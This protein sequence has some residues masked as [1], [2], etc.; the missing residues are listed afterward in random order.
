MKLRAKVLIPIG[1]VF[2][3]SFSAFIFFL[4]LDQSN[5]KRANLNQEMDTMTELVGTT[6]VAYLWNMDIGGLEQS[7]TSFLK[8]P[9]IVAVEIQDTSGKAVATLEDKEKPGEL[10]VKTVEI[11]HEGAKIGV[12]NVTFTDAIL[13]DEVQGIILQLVILG[14]FVFA[15]LMTVLYFVTN[16]FTKPIG[17]LLGIV[18]DMAQGEGNLAVTIPVESRDEIGVLSGHFNNFLG[19]LRTIVVNLRDVGMK[20]RTLGSNLE[21]STRDISSSS[22][23]IAASMKSMGERTNYLYEQIRLSSDGIVGINMSIDKVVEMIDAQAAA[24]NESSAA[25]EEM[26]A[27][28][29]NIERS[30]ENKLALA[31]KL[32]SMAQSSEE[33]M[34]ANVKEMDEI[35]Q[36]TRTISEMTKVINNIAGQTN[37]LAMNAAIEAAHA[38]DYGRGF[39]V[40]A[41]EIRKLAEQTSSNAK[42][43]SGSLGNIVKRIQGASV[44]TKNSSESITQVIRGIGDVALGMDETMSGLKEI[45]LGNK[46]ITE[47]LTDLNK[48]TGEVMTSGR[49]MREG[50]GKVEETFGLIT[51]IANENKRG[52]G[53]MSVGIDSISSAMVTIAKLSVE[54]SGTLVDLD[55]EI[56]KFK[57]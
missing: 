19:K 2:F 56:N 35:S 49:Q 27:N 45:S 18:K 44:L 5:K 9:A 14:V 36:S 51:E 52:I 26:I 32:E 38:G 1:I 16:L 33:S 53:E 30:T 8:S 23:Q 55:Q 41:D 37:L 3:V 42:T 13:R 17:T 22:V 40:V 39:S 31:R 28:V 25:I 54:N 29:A 57:I 10:I 12:A 47:A 15:L 20:N 34:R 7:L 4:A 46:Q 48:M 43:I 11:L 50:T 24:V 21:S 6:N